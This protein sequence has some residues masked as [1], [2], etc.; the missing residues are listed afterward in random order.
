MN[1]TQHYLW[2]A[3]DQHGNVLDVLVQSRRNALAA[4]KFC[5]GLLKGLEYVARVVPAPR[6]GRGVDG[7][8]GLAPKR[9]HLRRTGI[10]LSAFHVQLLWP[11]LR[12]L[13][14]RAGYKRCTDAKCSF[15]APDIAEDLDG[16][17][18][19]VNIDIAARH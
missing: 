2:R 14:E 5:R 1:G 17:G 8:N 19:W 10:E 3:V 9:I 4:K 6:R 11:T 18:E 16:L 7:L 15:K 13:A 12:D